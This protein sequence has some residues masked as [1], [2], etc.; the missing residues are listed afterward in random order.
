MLVYWMMYYMSTGPTPKK[1]SA[2]GKAAKALGYCQPV[3][4]L[5]KKK[6]GILPSGNLT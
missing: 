4:Q 1:K 6:V 5:G 2:Q 3:G